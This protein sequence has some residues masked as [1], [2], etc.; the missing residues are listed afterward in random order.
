MTTFDYSRFLE[1]TDTDLYAYV[2]PFLDPQTPLSQE[3]L[4]RML[5]ELPM[6]DEPHLVYAIELGPDHAPD[7]FVPVIP[8]Y[9]SHKSQAVRC[10][11]SR[12]IDRL[13]DRLITKEFVD[14]ARAAL[15]SCPERESATWASFIDDLDKRRRA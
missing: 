15:S 7:L 10:T 1:L 2:M 9:L 4:N 14:A 11:A 13:P 3:V 5:V 6:Y 12:A 8:Q